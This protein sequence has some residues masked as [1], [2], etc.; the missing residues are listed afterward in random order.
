MAETT[1]RPHALV[2]G[3]SS[4]IGEALCLALAR[5]GYAVTACARREDLLRGLVERIE[6]EGGRA[7]MSG[8][9]VSSRED[10]RKAVEGAEREFGPVELVIANAGIGINAPLHKLRLEWVDQMVDV[11]LKGA[12][13][14]IL[15]VLPGML[16]RRRGQVVGISSLA[17]YRGLPSSALYSATKAGLSTFLE[18]IRPEAAAYGVQVTDICPGFIRTP[19]TAKNR[20]PMPFLMD[21]DAAAARILRAIRRGRARYGFPWPMHAAMRL[22]RALPIPVYDLLMRWTAARLPPGGGSKGQ[23]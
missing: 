10:V 16:Q 21:V 1:Q 14:V 19:L 18:G 3:A 11:N 9:D 22:L 6:R 15:A 5:Q 12:L 13:Y 2:T 8:L 20:H 7:R 4:G 23:S 17:G